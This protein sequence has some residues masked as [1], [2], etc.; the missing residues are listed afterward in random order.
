[1]IIK[2]GNSITLVFAITDANGV[3]ITNLSTALAIKFMVKSNETDADSSAKISKSLTSGITIN[4]PAIGNVSI[5]L[6]ATDTAITAGTYFMGLQI[7]WPT[8]KEEVSIKETFDE[9]MDINTLQII[10]DIVR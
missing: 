2:A 5:A 8:Y 4:T 7:E 1:M 9:T 6:T 10:Q 3:T